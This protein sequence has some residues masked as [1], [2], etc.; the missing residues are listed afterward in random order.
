M[1][2]QGDR[3]RDATAPS[4]FADKRE[5][6]IDRTKIRQKVK[7]DIDDYIAKGGTIDQIPTGVSANHVRSSRS[8]IINPE[9]YS[10]EKQS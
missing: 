2:S 8:F 9:K 10:H 3:F 5:K 1:K 6:Q 7:A 4:R